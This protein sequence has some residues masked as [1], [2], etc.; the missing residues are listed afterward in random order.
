MLTQRDYKFSNVFEVNEFRKVVKRFE[1][2]TIIR[3]HPA[4]PIKVDT[5]QVMVPPWHIEKL[6]R[7]AK[8]IY[9]DVQIVQ[10]TEQ[11]SNWWERYTPMVIIVAVSAAAL[12]VLIHTQC[13]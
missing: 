13:K 2:F 3:E 10:K 11:V 1:D 6:D 5:V 9:Q 4:A 7:S 8:Q 12:C